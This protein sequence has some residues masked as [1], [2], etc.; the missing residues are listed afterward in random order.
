MSTARFVVAGKVQG[1]WFRAATRERALALQLHGFARNLDDGGV[2]VVAVGDAAAIEELARWL[3]EGPPMAK[4]SAVER[5]SPATELVFEG[6][7]TL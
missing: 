1:V 6:F 7:V 4:V 3:W 2:E 5:G